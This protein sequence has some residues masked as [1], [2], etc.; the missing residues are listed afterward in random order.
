MLGAWTAGGGG[1]GDTRLHSFGRATG[2]DGASLERSYNCT[3][4]ANRPLLLLRN[5]QDPYA[6]PG[7]CAADAPPPQTTFSPNLDVPQR[8]RKS[9]PD[10]WG[11]SKN[12][13]YITLS[14]GQEGQVQSQAMQ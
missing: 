13:G 14:G 3:E 2:A 6:T 12:S 1:G 5:Q 10:N 9:V 7:H 8:H 4:C 11:V